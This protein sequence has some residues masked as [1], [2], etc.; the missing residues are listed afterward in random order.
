[1]AANYLQR[2]AIVGSRTVSAAKPAVVG[3]PDMPGSALSAG[4]P[5]LAN[6]PSLSDRVEDPSRPLL[7]LERVPQVG[8]E[9]VER[10]VESAP[11]SVTEPAHDLAPPQARGSA[12]TGG[13]ERVPAGDSA[14]EQLTI[15]QALQSASTSHLRPKTRFFVRAP[16]ELRPVAGPPSTPTAEPVIPLLRDE[17]IIAPPRERRPVMPPQPQPH[18]EPIVGLPVDIPTPT[19]DPEPAVTAQSIIEPRSKRP[20][21]GSSDLAQ[22]PMLAA[23]EPGRSDEMI[24]VASA[25]ETESR[26][27]D[28]P[29]QVAQAAPT[30]RVSVPESQWLPAVPRSSAADSG[31]GS[32]ITIGRVEVHVNNRAPP[33][34]VV[35]R[36]ER[37][38]SWSAPALLDAHYLDRFFLRR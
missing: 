5:D 14:P 33:R 11:S 19:S 8:L 10:A 20:N 34:P 12:A 6:P 21:N 24:A 32:R 38:V 25:A 18:E 7:D 22:L 26:P 30:H 29:E 16:R 1:M 17:A 28:P 31:N 3:P 37:R 23:A 2:I 9:P 15:P 4:P 36:P 27:V 13:A 35:L